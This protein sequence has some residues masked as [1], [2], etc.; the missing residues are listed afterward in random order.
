MSNLREQAKKLGINLDQHISSA[1]KVR[2]YRSTL[3][4]IDELLDTKDSRILSH[5]A[6]TILIKDVLEVIEGMRGVSNITL[7]KG[8]SVVAILTNLRKAR[9]ELYLAATVLK[10]SGQNR[11]FFRALTNCQGYISEALNYFRS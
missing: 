6:L 11:S 8:G 3:I 10:K 1:E 4:A 7:G 5:G 2:L 9:D